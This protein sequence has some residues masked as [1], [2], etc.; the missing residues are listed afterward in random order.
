MLKLS[1]PI[2]L[3]FT[4]AA[5]LPLVGCAHG[6]GRKDTAYVARDVSSLYTAAKRS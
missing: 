6:K 2:A 5:V 4:A 1:R 3:L